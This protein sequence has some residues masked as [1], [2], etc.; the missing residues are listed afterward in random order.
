MQQETFEEK[1]FTDEDA[2]IILE[3][4]RPEVEKFI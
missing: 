1:R 2:A 3:S 4:N